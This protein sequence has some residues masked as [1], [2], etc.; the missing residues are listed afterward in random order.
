M[1]IWI[2]QERQREQERG[3]Q[4]RPPAPD[5]LIELGIEQGRP[6]VLVHAGDCHM[7]R[8]RWRAIDR[9]EAWRQR[10]AGVEGCTY[11]SLDELLGYLDG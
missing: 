5:W 7:V 2:A 9:A 8:G 6:A 1:D 10:A 3:E 4:A 11:C